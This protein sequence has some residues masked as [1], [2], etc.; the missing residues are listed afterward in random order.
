MILFWLKIGFSFER[1]IG[2]QLQQWKRGGQELGQAFGRL[3]FLR[4]FSGVICIRKDVRV[5]SRGEEFQGIFM[6]TRIVGFG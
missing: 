6:K 4:K 3:N 5:R 1:C 2:L